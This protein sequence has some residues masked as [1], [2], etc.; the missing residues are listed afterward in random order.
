[1]VRF[2]LLSTH[3]VV[4]MKEI[5]KNQAIAKLLRNNIKNP[6]SGP[7][8]DGNSLILK[9]ILPFPFPPEA[10][11]E[12]GSEI[13]VYYSFGSIESK[14]VEDIMVNFDVLVSSD[15]W[16]CNTGE[17]HLESSYIRP[18]MI[19]SELMSAL[20]KPITVTVRKVQGSPNM[21]KRTTVGL[22]FKGF[23]HIFANDKVQGVQA[24]A[25]LVNYSNSEKTW[26]R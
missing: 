16:L 11:I 19:M 8:V 7:E 21:D 13:R 26:N 6:L 23:R 3:L 17:G 15:L 9:E 14:V 24:T 10:T 25:R 5:A 18:L 20:D 4:M 12:S 2:E 1:M 22:E